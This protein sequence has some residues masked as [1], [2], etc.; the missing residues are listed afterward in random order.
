MPTPKYQQDSSNPL[1]N[2]DRENGSFSI[3]AQQKLV[4]KDER[5]EKA[6]W[7]RKRNTM[8]KN[9]IKRQSNL[10]ANLPIIRKRNEAL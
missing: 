10:L 3:V 9:E 5:V 6:N 4:V 7:L 1:G 2:N 8:S